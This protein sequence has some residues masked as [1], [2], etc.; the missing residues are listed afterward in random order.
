[1]ESSAPKIEALSP[2]CGWYKSKPV[3]PSPY[4]LSV[5]SITDV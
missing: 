2:F 5:A 4:V 3:V 1:M